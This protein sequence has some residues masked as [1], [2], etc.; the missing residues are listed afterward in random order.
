MYFISDDI[1]LW[2][3]YGIECIPIENSKQKTLVMDDNRKDDRVIEIDAGTV[4]A[5]FMFKFLFI[6]MVE[7][8]PPPP[9]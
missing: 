6:F 4:G 3:P 7:D 5:T 9:H 1:A 2:R 8:L